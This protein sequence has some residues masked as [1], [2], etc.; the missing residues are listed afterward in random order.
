MP[1]PLVNQDEA[2][3]TD[4][5]S[6]AHGA[7]ITDARP[8][9]PDELARLAPRPH[10]LAETGIPPR[11]LEMLLLKHLSHVTDLDKAGLTERLALPGKLVDELL[12]KLKAEALLEIRSDGRFE[13]SLRYGLTHKGMTLAQ[14]E[15]QRDG[16]L[17]PAPVSLEQYRHL[18]LRQTS[19]LD[20]VSPARFTQGMADVWLTEA[21][22]N[23]LG[24][25]INSGRAIFIYGHPG[26]GKTFVSRRL[27]RLFAS[28]VLI[29]H[30]LCIGEQVLAV[31]DPLVHKPKASRGRQPLRLDEGTDPRWILCE[32]P[33][34]VVGG[35]LTTDMLDVGYDADRHCNK[36]PLQL[37][38]NNGILIIDDLGRQKV[39]VDAILNRWI[40]P[41]EEHIDYL[42]ISSG[43][44]FEVP[45]EQVLVF[46]TN[47][48]PHELVDEAF[49]RRIGYKI[50]F[51]PISREGYQQLWQAQCARQGLECS[52]EVFAYLIDELHARDGIPL[53]PC[54]P[55]DLVALC[56]DQINFMQLPSMLSKDLIA[57]IW[58]SYFVTTREHGGYHG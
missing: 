22:I 11:V 17:G 31:F 33:E 41:L 15:W 38:A 37:K 50:E 56:R 42:S 49:L 21:M 40:V 25:A 9:E 1:H 7:T 58:A 8:A 52:E 24:P 34:V 23:R 27:V 44:H 5:L 35:E 14:Y 4:A 51:C 55:R 10:T 19:R 53:L 29:P 28:S 32:R 39:A 48:R 54:H 47:Y 3:L 57:S 13:R 43:E 45:F 18:V 30:A 46:S 2:P 12:Q 16:Y 6:Q 20:F 36:A 26:T